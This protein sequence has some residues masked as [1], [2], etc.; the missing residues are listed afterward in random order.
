M[1][2]S[3]LFLLYFQ[4][5][6]F[7]QILLNSDFKTINFIELIKIVFIYHFQALFCPTVLWS[8]SLQFDK[9]GD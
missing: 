7:R 3:F 1:L 5:N 9:I 8:F 6:N 2:I 4:E